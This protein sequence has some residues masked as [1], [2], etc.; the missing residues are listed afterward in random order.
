MTANPEQPDEITERFLRGEC[1]GDDVVDEKRGYREFE[2]GRSSNSP[3]LLRVAE[4][5]AR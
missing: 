1:N 2:R 3:L 4:R 5:M